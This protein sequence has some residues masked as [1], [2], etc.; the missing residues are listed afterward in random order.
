MEQLQGT[1]SLLSHLLQLAL[2][3]AVV[4]I[5]DLLNVSQCTFHNCEYLFSEYLLKGYTQNLQEVIALLPTTNRT[6]LTPRP[7]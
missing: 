6:L 2:A 1:L 5:Q 4:R 3:T 7:T